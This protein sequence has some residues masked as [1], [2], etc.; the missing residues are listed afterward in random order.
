MSAN[1]LMSEVI[2]CGSRAL[3][4]VAAHG[5][6]PRRFPGTGIWEMDL[7][8]YPLEKSFPHLQLHFSHGKETPPVQGECH[9]QGTKL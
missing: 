9:V 3:L 4:L 5:T 8:G 6:E 2:K 7:L 1:R